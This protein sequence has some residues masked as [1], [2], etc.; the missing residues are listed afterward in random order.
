MKSPIQIFLLLVFIT[1]VSSFN[2]L[3]LRAG[4]ITISDADIRSQQKF[5]L[6]IDLQMDKQFKEKRKDINVIASI[7]SLSMDDQLNFYFDYDIICPK[8]QCLLNFT[9]VRQSEKVNP[10]FTY[11]LTIDYFVARGM[12][13][14]DLNMTSYQEHIMISDIVSYDQ[15]NVR[16]KLAAKLPKNN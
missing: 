4:T 1:L 13:I 16:Q 8:Q 15:N 11:H 12:R 3:P 2:I 14:Y 10:D 7:T 6:E 9:F 5:R